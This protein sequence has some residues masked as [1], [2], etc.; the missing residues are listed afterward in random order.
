MRAQSVPTGYLEKCQIY[1][2]GTGDTADGAVPA[3]AIVVFEVFSCGNY[4]CNGMLNGVVE[5]DPK[6]PFYIGMKHAAVGSAELSAQIWATLY[7]F[8]TSYQV[9]EIL[10]D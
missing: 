1:V 9:V 4:R 7:V 8:Q 5:T 6:H 2:D 10:Y 3:W